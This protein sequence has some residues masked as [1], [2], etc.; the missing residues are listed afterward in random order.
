MP[1]WFRPATVT[2]GIGVEVLLVLLYEHSSRYPFGFQPL[3]IPIVLCGALV[4]WMFGDRL[5]APAL[6]TRSGTSYSWSPLM[7]VAASVG[8]ACALA[9]AARVASTPMS[10]QVWWGAGIG[11]AVAGCI[12]AEVNV[13]RVTQ[14]LAA[15]RVVVAEAAILF[16]LALLFRLPHLATLPSFV[17]GDE[18][19]CGIWAR[20]FNAGNR[21]L[22]SIGWH[23]L[24]MLSYAFGGLSMRVFGDS[25]LGLRLGNA[26]LGSVG[27]VV[28]FLLGIELYSRR[29]AALSALLMATGFVA[30][31]FSRS[32]LHDIQGPVWTA[33]VVYLGVLWLRRGGALWALLTGV[34]M[35]LSVTMHWSARICP[36]LVGLLVVQALVAGRAVRSERLRDLPWMGLGVLITG[37][38]VYGMFLA[39]P[40]S[41]AARESAIN[42]FSPAV[43][44]HVQAVYGTTAL[45]TVLPQQIWRTLE[46]FFVL[47]DSSTLISWNHGMFDP[48]TAALCVPAL[49]VCAR[50]WRSWPEQLLLVWIASVLAASVLTIDPPWWPRMVPM[51]PAIALLVGALLDD[52]VRATD[53]LPVRSVSPAFPLTGAVLGAIIALNAHALYIDYPNEIAGSYLTI[54]TV[55]GSYLA[56]TPAAAKTILLSDNSGLALSAPDIQ[57]LAPQAGG[58]TVGA[59][60]ELSVCA[61][62]L[63]LPELYVLLPGRATDLRE[64]QEQHPGGVVRVLGNAGGPIVAYAM[65]AT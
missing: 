25:L 6:L 27:V 54:G 44:G 30:A 29:A 3:F 4:A 15:Q 24:P 9:G 49:L 33:I 12:A 65:P 51:L 13:R 26:L 45:T 5:P 53:Q 41:V 64:I 47:G 11:V 40:G 8:V 23:G 7:I 35:V 57:F 1:E 63:P 34:S 38:P 39:N 37:L 32:G 19:M 31:T 10:A 43:A 21:S 14:I 36:L 55:V 60:Q 28:T 61:A 52:V 18:A 48:V 2:V 59:A 50:R 56:T 58:C 62:A 16:L 22:L 20:L 42:L 17:A 46:T